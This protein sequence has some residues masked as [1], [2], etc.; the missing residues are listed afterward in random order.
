TKVPYDAK[1]GKRAMVNQAYTWSTFRE[2][3]LMYAHRQEFAGIGFVM[4]GTEGIVGIDIDGR[5]DYELIKTLDSYSELTP[6]GNGC[7]IF[8]KADVVLTDKR[9]PDIEIYNDRRFFTVT[10]NVLHR[11]GINERQS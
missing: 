10:G 7:R 8:I 9:M 4:T 2:A 3:Q 5:I 1:A 6:S 11:T